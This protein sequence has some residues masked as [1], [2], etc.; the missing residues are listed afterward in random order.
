[1]SMYARD[2]LFIGG[3]W[4][5]SSGSGVLE[6]I[7]PTTEEI[8]GRIPDPTTDD[9]DRAVASARAAFEEGPWPRMAIEERASF[10][11]ALVGHLMNNLD[12]AVELQID[13][14]GGTRKFNQ[15]TTASIPGFLDRM[16]VDT[17]KV[18]L[19]ELRD[20]VVGKVLVARD[21]IG[22]AAGVIPWNSPVMVA[23]TKLFPSLL[24]GCP[25]VL[26]PAPESPLSAYVL[27][28]AVEA[29]EIPSGVVSIV[30]G[31][32]EVGE[33]LVSHRGVDKV[34]FT[35]STP[36]G[37]RIA[38]ICGEQLKA[39]T[40]ELGGKSAAIFLPDTDVERFLPVLLGNCVRNVGQICISLS[41][42]LVPED[43]QPFLVERLIGAISAMKVGDPHDPDT[44]VGP[45]VA[46]RQRAR[47]E[48]YIEAGRQDGA[49]LA[50]G[51]GRPDGF[52]RGWYVEP[53][54][55]TEVE[56]AMRI[57]QEEI[58]GPVVSVLTYRTVDEAVAIAND[59]DYGLFGSVYGPSPDEALE[60]ALR[61]HTGTCAINE[62]PPSGGGG[63]FGGWK[64]SGL[65]RERAREGLESF[66]EL[67]SIAMPAGVDVPAEML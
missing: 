19:R 65:G 27:A 38:A 47:V 64:Q 10:L 39:V 13:E 7:S 9:V 44:D 67:R 57:A 4:E 34:T 11:R 45:L 31:G 36:A 14:M 15:M 35:G 18:R 23:V 32:R 24:M 63:P 40:A 22:V 50:L 46:E 1:M 66:L 16:L 2:A 28:E 30:A 56:P 41:R 29:A 12:E 51:G 3:T 55:F 49:K 6:V 53:T 17:A 5:R 20:G 62:G 8:V 42:V 33:H 48:S 52:D 60:V 43:M 59:S 25:M 58:F 21:P 54:V 61:I 37:R 26:K